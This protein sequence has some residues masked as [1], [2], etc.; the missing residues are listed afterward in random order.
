MNVTGG[1]AGS[2]N[3]S[4]GGAVGVY[5][6]TPT[7]S[8]A[9]AGRSVGPFA[10]QYISPP[11]TFNGRLLQPSAGLNPGTLDGVNVYGFPTPGQASTFQFLRAGA[12]AG[13]R[14]DGSGLNAGGLFGG[15]G[16]NA[17]SGGGSAGGVGG[18]IIEYFIV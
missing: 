8:V 3:S 5:G 16:G 15:G 2:V 4:G 17:G 7:A 13:G 6:T 9:S 14:G 10:D 12:F 18:V 11:N 1:S